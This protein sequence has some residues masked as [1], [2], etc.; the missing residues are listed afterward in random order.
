MFGD[1]SLSY[2]PNEEFTKLVGPPFDGR[3][4]GGPFAELVEVEG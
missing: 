2:T 4:V 3:R 1:G